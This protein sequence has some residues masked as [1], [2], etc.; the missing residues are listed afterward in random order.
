[1]GFK[2]NI[3][4]ICKTHHPFQGGAGFITAPKVG[5]KKNLISL[6]VFDLQGH[7]ASTIEL[8][9]GLEQ[10]SFILVLRLEMRLQ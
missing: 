10:Q 4:G 8:R 9:L 6:P 2:S 3:V 7:I 1:M 5:V